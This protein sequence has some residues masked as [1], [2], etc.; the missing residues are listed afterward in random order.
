M[1]IYDE[2]FSQGH[3]I[4]SIWG[5]SECV[6]E[7][8]CQARWLQVLSDDTNDD[9]LRLS[10]EPGVV[11]DALLRS[12]ELKEGSIGPPTRYLGANIERVQLE[13]GRETWAMPSRDYV[14][15]AVSNVESMRKLDGEPPFK[16]H[17]DYKRPYPREYRPKKQDWYIW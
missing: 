16:F 3:W 2:R 8:W 1:G 12:Y 10:H 17:G 13:D 11:M 6:V 14:D 9:I 15:S 7:T 4:Q 5:W